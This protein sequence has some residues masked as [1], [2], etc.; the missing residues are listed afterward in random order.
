MANQKPKKSGK[1][2]STP[3]ENKKDVKDT[4]E[5]K[6]TDAKEVNEVKEVKE[7]VARE[8]AVASTMDK[9]FR[10]FFSRK[11]DKGENI[12]TIFKSARIWGALIGEAVGTM[13]IVTLLIMLGLLGMNPLYIVFG[14]LCIYLAVVG[15]SGANL[16]PIITVGMMATR[17][18]SAIRGILY[19]LAQLLGGWIGLIIVNA[20]RLGSGS[21]LD[22]PVMT[23]VTGESFWG[24][25][26]VE[27]FGAIIIAFCFARALGYARRNPLAFAMTVTSGIA[28]AVIIAIVITQGFFGETN[29]FIFNPI[30][31]LMYQ[32]LPTTA[33][34]IGELA[35][36]AGLAAAAYIILPMIGGIIGFYFS[37]FATHAAGKGYYSEYDEGKLIEK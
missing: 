5:T 32:V 18:M 37:D 20:F 10:G 21:M 23:E 11:Y 4:K 29:T 12:L 26:L 27:L 16:N 8:T 6:S 19:M 7:T 31:A 24:V 30:A 15:L 14:A 33:D 17:R 35:A 9:P 1:K 25:A 28:L 2:N 34:N 3:P 13:L 36:N 22:L